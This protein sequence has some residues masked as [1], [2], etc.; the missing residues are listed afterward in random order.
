MQVGWFFCAA[1]CASGALEKF[2]R[3]TMN[4]TELVPWDRRRTPVTEENRRNEELDP[5]WAIPAAAQERAK[6]IPI[7]GG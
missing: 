7:N 4:M 6:R 1:H 5:L 3:M 2:A